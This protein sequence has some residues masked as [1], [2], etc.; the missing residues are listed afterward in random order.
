DRPGD[1][2]YLLSFIPVD[3]GVVTN[4]SGSHLE[5]FGT[6]AAIAKEKGL[7]LTELDREGVAI[8]NADNPY[9]VKLLKKTKAQT[10]FSYGFDESAT[11]RAE[12]VHWQESMFDGL[13]F[14][15][16][17]ESKVLP[18]R[19]PF[20]IAQHHIPAVLAA[21]A[22]GLSLKLNLV[23]M[24]Q[25]LAEFRSLSG[26]MRPLEGVNGSV[27]ID[28]TYNSSPASLESAFQTLQSVP[29]NR[30][31][32]ILGDMLELGATSE[33]DHKRV[34]EWLQQ[35]SVERAIL[36]GTRM[37]KAYEELLKMGWSEHQVW[38]LESPVR[39]GE[40]ATQ[41]IVPGDVVLCKGSQGMRIEIAVKTLLAHPDQ[42]DELLCRQSSEWKARAFQSV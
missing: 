38:W 15:L 33:R 7:I 10:V 4:I 32:A 2:E 18:V 13:L 41:W 20:V 14:R 25:S 24:T 39:A 19:L 9:T 37:R 36:V 28:D 27:V 35:Y 26:R 17:Y 12:S 40:I 21:M 42:A 11:L 8:V 5:F 22:V 30:R 3:I 16:R 29:A 1:M 23:E 34:A 6:L 31:V